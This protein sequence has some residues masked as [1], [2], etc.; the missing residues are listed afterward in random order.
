MF[1]MKS[2]TV[3]HYRLFRTYTSLFQEVY[4]LY[5]WQKV[6]RLRI[7]KEMFTFRNCFH[8]FAHPVS[9]RKGI[10]D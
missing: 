1:S 9:L 4:M 10:C 7:N 8:Y 5:Y 6:A 3:F 2:G